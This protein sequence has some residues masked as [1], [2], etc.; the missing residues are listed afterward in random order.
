MSKKI[1][2]IED[3]PII[4]LDISQRLE[5]AG[6]MVQCTCSNAQEALTILKKQLPD[7][8]IMDINL[9]D[10]IDGIQLANII[11]QD[12][13]IPFIYLTAYYD[14]ITQQRAKKTEPYAFL[15]KPYNDIE[16]QMS[17]DL[18]FDRFAKEKD[19]IIKDLNSAEKTL[20][21]FHEHSYNEFFMKTGNQEF[22]KVNIEHINYI[23]AYD[24]YSYFYMGSK[25][26]LVNISLKEI[27][28]KLKKTCL[29]R[30]HRSFI[31]NIKK[32]DLIKGNIAIVKDKEI[33]IG[34]SY[35]VLL[36]ENLN[37]L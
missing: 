27:E 33:P 5:L 17:I 29:I 7:M 12:F 13:G 22:Q 6:Y 30:I 1:M 31:I 28:I 25:K 10:T 15:V 19:L 21:N 34:G 32:L 3:E 14:K 18:A 11:N 37:V 16:L 8:I 4:A 35:K 9:N 36:L 20:I 2:I 26:L 23:E 24:I